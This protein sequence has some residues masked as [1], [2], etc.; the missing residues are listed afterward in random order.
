MSQPW[1]CGKH[2]FASRLTCVCQ[3]NVPIEHAV[4]LHLTVLL[5]CRWVAGERTWFW[6]SRS[7]VVTLFLACDRFLV[8]PC[9]LTD[10]FCFALLRSRWWWSAVRCVV[11]V[12]FGTQMHSQVSLVA[13]VSN[14]AIRFL[15]VYVSTPREIIFQC[16]WCRWLCYCPCQKAGALGCA[17]GSSFQ[18]GKSM[19]RTQ[20]FFFLTRTNRDVPRS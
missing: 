10:P 2:V 19:C 3:N 13:G 6:L 14:A 20:M 5:R 1:P 8:V 16:F 12:E 7:H 4:H 17:G 15:G 11:V 9:H 18:F